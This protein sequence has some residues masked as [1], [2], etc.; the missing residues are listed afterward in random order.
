[1]GRDLSAAH[2]CILS[3]GQAEAR[4]LSVHSLLGEA[5]VTPPGLSFPA[6]NGHKRRDVSPNRGVLL[7]T[8]CASR[9]C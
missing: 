8:A 6:R 5:G 9:G 2:P 4:R 7:H 3:P 1:M